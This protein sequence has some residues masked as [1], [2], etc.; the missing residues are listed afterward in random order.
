MEEIRNKLLRDHVK[1]SFNTRILVLMH[2]MGGENIHHTVMIEK[3][4]T[5]EEYDEGGITEG[6][7]V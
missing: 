3:P 1:N 4:F 5:N 6:E 7:I 2:K